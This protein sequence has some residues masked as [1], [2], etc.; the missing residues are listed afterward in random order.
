MTTL[1]RRTTDILVL[2]SGGA[3]LLGALH[4]KAARP[5][6][7][8][9]VAVKGLLGKSGC[10]RMVQG[11]YNVAL[12]PEDSA[13][14]HF[15]DT[16]HGGGWLNDQDLAWTLV[17]VAQRRIRE[18]ENRWGCF[19]D[20]NAD[21]TIHQK[22]FAG[23]TFDRTVHKGDLTGIEIIN[24][25]AEQTWARGIERMEEHRAVALLPARDGSRLA[26]VLLVDVRS[27]AL[28][29]VQAKAVLLGTG[30]GP[31]MYTYHTPSGDKSCDGMAM[32]LRAG[33]AL[34]DM[35]M[36][37]FHPTGV[38][39]GPGTR[40]TGTII[41]EGLRGS[42]GYLLGGDGQRFMH[43]YDPRNER[44][45]RDIVSR[46]M[47]REMLAGNVNEAGGLWIEMAHLGPDRVRREF[48]GMVERCA[49]MGFDLAGGRV[50]V[51]PTAHYMMGGV[52]FR[53]DGATALPGL[54]A[55]GE[56]TGGVHGANRLGGNGVANST[57]FGGIA[58]DSMAAWV[59]REG[60]IEDPDPAALEAA[61][62]LVH[63]PF[64]QPAAPL[65]PIRDA[66]HALM[67]EKAGILRD[68]P[69]LAE[70]ARGLDALEAELDRTGVDG[71]ARAFN[72]AWHDW[73]N[74]RSLLL[75][76]RAIVA[77]ATAREESRG[78][79]WRED[80]PQTR[81]AA[82]GLAST[83]TTLGGDGRIALA[84]QPVAFSRVRPG[85][86]LLAAVAAE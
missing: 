4:A 50:P 77:A 11:G 72:L 23:Q 51:V 69:G 15:M 30:G 5:D 49:D 84:W 55:A 29:L 43:R 64:A 42:G 66:L 3:G 27:G 53:P 33:L 75:V 39:A 19:F 25:L 8:V 28:V 41:E 20:R 71:G 54:F 81:D 52:V 61:L 17:T 58:G 46:S 78:A 10:T 74:L 73:L 21:G 24:R 76:S 83:V 48:K 80:F 57:V 14:R 65:S 35:E 22:A 63:A 40:M 1:E 26:G 31:T 47:Y 67:W 38:L 2:G 44:A 34:R 62:A 6:L 12:A 18:L 60:A 37:Q 13:E 36:V 16:I 68:A 86:S 82:A 7:R 32:A 59:P 56:D 70:A 45:T 9:T 85:E 79:H